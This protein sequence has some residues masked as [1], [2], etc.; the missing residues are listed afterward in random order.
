MA[1]DSGTLSNPSLNCPICGGEGYLLGRL[2]SKFHCR[3]RD[4]GIEWSGEVPADYVQLYL[5]E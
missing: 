4:C 5:E 3:C 2:G 1:E